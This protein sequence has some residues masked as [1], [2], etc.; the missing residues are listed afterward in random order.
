[1]FGGPPRRRIS[2][3][4]SRS[5]L[6]CRRR[7]AEDPLEHLG[8]RALR[9]VAGRPRRPRRPRGN[10]HGRSVGAA[11][12]VRILVGP[13]VHAAVAGA[14]NQRDRRRA[15][16]PVVLTLGLE[17]RR[18]HPRAGLLADLDRLAH[19]VE[20]RRGCRPV[21]AGHV[22]QR[23]AALAAFVRNVDAVHSRQFLR[24][25]HDL[26]GHAPA[27]RLVL[28]ARRD[29]DRAL[30]QRL[31][32]QRAH[33]RPLLR[34]RR[35]PHIVAHHPAADRAVADQ[36]QGVGADAE[37][38]D[39]R[40]LLRDRPRRAAVLVD[41]DRGDALRDQV[42]RGA[43]AGVLVAEPA[44]RVG[45]VV[46]VR[47]DVDEAGRDVL[48]GCVDGARGLGASQ[49][50]DRGDAPAADRDVGREPRVAGPVEDPAVPDQQVVRL[51]RLLRGQGG[52]A[53]GED[54]AG[55]KGHAFHAVILATLPRGRIR[56]GGGRAAQRT[57][58]STMVMPAATDSKCRGLK[59][60]SSPTCSRASDAAMSAS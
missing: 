56:A 38:L 44:A 52:G 37:L 6:L 40:P 55:E 25:L 60:S 51:R 22:P 23:I 24:E 17:M 42:G 4:M 20:Q 26:V 32:H 13:H 50:A 45:P 39:E 16:S 53:G 3:A 28:E 36:Q 43:A 18:D 31:P 57:D 30:L 35:P 49:R 29:A 9:R 21:L 58:G 14:L 1:M 41:D 46:G 59:V 54:K 10:Q 34:R 7:I 15:R 27:A 19:R 12:R 8:A 11:G 48:A 5:H 33:L 47:V 2:W